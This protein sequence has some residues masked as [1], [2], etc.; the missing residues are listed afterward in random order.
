[1]SKISRTGKKKKRKKI[2]T[3]LEAIY[4]FL[5]S[6][7][8]DVD[9]MCWGTANKHYHVPRIL[10]AVGPPN[11]FGNMRHAFGMSPISATRFRKLTFVLLEKE[12]M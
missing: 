11:P 1:M 3:S 4:S 8:P 9:L 7:L 2:S 12:K 10:R 6:N 5:Q